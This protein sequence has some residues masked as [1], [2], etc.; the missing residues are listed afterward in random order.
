[1]DILSVL[2]EFVDKVDKVDKGCDI[3]FIEDVILDC[4]KIPLPHDNIDVV[5]LSNGKYFIQL[6]KFCNMF[7]VSLGFFFINI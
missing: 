3:S 2:V 1:M 7:C 6:F 5:V 4:D